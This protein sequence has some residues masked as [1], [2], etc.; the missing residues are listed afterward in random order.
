MNSDNWLNLARNQEVQSRIQTDSLLPLYG[1]V[2]GLHIVY[3][4]MPTIP[5]FDRPTKLSIEQQSVVQ[6]LNKARAAIL[7]EVEIDEVKEKLVNNSV[8][9]TSKFLHLLAPDKYAIWDGRVARVW[10]EPESISRSRYECSRTYLEYVKC[11][12]NL[13]TDNQILE[14]ISILRK[15]SSNLE[16]V[17]EL[18]I[19][20]LVLFHA[21]K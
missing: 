10:F 12:K 19:L 21:K 7:T 1:S 2:V 15:L 13:L 4:W 6:L 20:E 3:A 17:T 18:R 16:T 14:Q 11:L 5:D 9:G 8:V